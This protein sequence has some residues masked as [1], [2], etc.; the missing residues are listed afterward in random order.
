[1]NREWHAAHSMPPRATEAQ[2][3]AWH[4]DHAANCTCRPIPERLAARMR[5]LGIAV[6]GGPATSASE[7]VATL[8]VPNRPRD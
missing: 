1:M 6:P 7:P 8:P 5:T 4:L 2:R 3:I